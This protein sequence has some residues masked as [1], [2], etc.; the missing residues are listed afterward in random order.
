M[1][2]DTFI[3]IAKSYISTDGRER[4]NANEPSHKDVKFT[5]LQDCPKGDYHA[6]GRASESDNMYEIE[7]FAESE[8]FK[9][10]KYE[11]SDCDIGRVINPMYHSISVDGVSVFFAT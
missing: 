6:F 4:I 10:Q 5:L 7:Y 2:L 8:V 11:A 3:K 9:V 1:T